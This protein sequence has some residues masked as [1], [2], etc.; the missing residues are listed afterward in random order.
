MD[1]LVK[2]HK[3]LQEDKERLFVEYADADTSKA[4]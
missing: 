3:K 2:Q 4:G 1:K